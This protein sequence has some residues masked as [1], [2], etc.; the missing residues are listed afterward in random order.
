MKDSM[1]L[2]DDARTLWHGD[3]PGASTVRRLLPT[4]TLGLFALGFL[5]WVGERVGLYGSTVGILLLTFAA[6]LVSAG[7][8]WHFAIGL[9]RGAREQRETEAELR[10]SARHFDLSRD[11]A[12]TAGFD[13][14]FIQLNATWT[15]TLG[16]S[17]EEL[18]S[19][20]FV[21]FVH[22]DDRE[23]T[24]LESA[25]LA[26][27]D[28]TV[29]FCN[30]YALK[31]WA[32]LDCRAVTILEEGMIYASAREITARKEAE[33]ALAASQHQ[34]RQILATARDAFVSVDAAGLVLEWNPQA[35]EVF[36][37]SREEALGRHLAD[38]IFPP[39]VRDEY[40]G[41]VKRDLAD[42]RRRRAG[43]RAGQAFGGARGAPRRAVV[44]SLAARA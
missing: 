24:E 14:I 31:G 2:L 16:W 44:R 15:Q 33:F 20:P 5:R 29:N 39:A 9:E 3:G 38:M 4:V 13:G 37:Y 21:E 8:T 32:W 27:G 28:V 6:V 25:G 35:E 40:L 1:P 43:R 42:E 23:R 18:R 17:N 10:R 12:C 36:G 7:L 22:P 41:R 19:R 11:L 26:E 30:R 34:T